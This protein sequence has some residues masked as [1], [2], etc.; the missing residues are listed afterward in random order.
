MPGPLRLPP[1]A[2]RPILE[3][4]GRRPYMAGPTDDPHGKDGEKTGE[5]TQ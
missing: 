4:I 3:R 2:R 5:G 1:S